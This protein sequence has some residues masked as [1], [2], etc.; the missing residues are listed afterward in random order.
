MNDIELKLALNSL[1]NRTP[2]FFVQ[3]AFAD[4]AISPSALE[5]L[6]TIGTD[7]TATKRLIAMLKLT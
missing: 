6:K 1:E 4:C 5:I 3:E 7:T 2:E